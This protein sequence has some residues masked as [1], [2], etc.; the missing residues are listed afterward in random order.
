MLFFR[1]RFHEQLACQFGLSDL[2]SPTESND[3]EVELSLTSAQSDLRINDGGQDKDLT[4]LASDT[5]YNTWLLVDNTKDATKV[6]LNTGDGSSVSDGDQLSYSDGDAEIN[7]FSFRSGTVGDLR[8][9]FIKTGGG[10][11]DNA[12]PFYLDDIYLNS[13]VN[14]TNPVPEPGTFLLFGL[15]LLSMAVAYRIRASRR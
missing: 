2:A 15:S 11:S 13:A 1:F 12:G 14:L 9:F 5:W 6:W 8:S 10:S 7:T 4:S 3:F